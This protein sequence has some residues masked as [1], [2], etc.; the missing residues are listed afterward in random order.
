[1][2]LALGTRLGAYEIVGLLGSGGMGEVYRARDTKL[3]R[4]VAIK[5][6]STAAT[7]DADRLRRFRDEARAASS[8]NHP[9]IL[10][11][12]DFGDVDGRPFIVTELVE[13]ETIGQRLRAGPIEPSETIAIVTQVAR[14]LSA[15]HALGIVH[16]DIKP[17]NV[18]VRP[19]GYVKVLD[20]G[21]AK[22]SDS[23]RGVDAPTELRTT[24]G[25]IVGTPRYM[26][27]EQVRGLPVD[28]R[29]DIW[30]IGVMLYEMIL[31]RP[32]FAGPTPADLAS[33]ILMSEPPLDGL[34]SAAGG[35]VGRVVGRA[36]SKNPLERYADA[37]E[38]IADLAAAAPAVDAMPAIARR[39][40]IAPASG[41]SNLSLQLTSFVGRE[42]D[43]AGV[44]RVLAGARFVMLTGAGGVGKTRL[45]LRVGAECAPHFADGVWFVDLAP[46]SDGAQVTG[47]IAGVLGVRDRPDRPIAESLCDR[48]RA[49]TL[50][51]VLDNCEHLVDACAAL[52][53]QL[54]SACAGIKMLATSREALG[55][56]GE[57]TWR[58]R[59]LGVPEAGVVDPAALMLVESAQLFVQRA[60]AVRPEFDV[61]ADNA[62]AVGHICRRL[63]GLPLAIELA[64]A[65]LRSMSAGEIATRLDDRFR[66][67]TG[68]S[69]AALPRQRTLEATVSWSYELLSDLERLLF[70]RLSVFAG[71]WT[72]EAAEQVCRL[73]GEPDVDIAD[74]IA[75][76]VDRSLVAADETASGRTRYRLLE[77]LRQFGRDR[78]V[79]RG[80]A[81]DVRARHLSWAVAHAERIPPQNTT[82]HEPDVAAEIDNLRT[83]LEWACETDAHEA[84]LRLISSASWILSLA[85]RRR[86]LR[87]LLPFAADAPPAVQSRVLFVAGSLA[88]MVGD[89]RW[90]VETLDA[91]AEISAKTG[92]V[93]HQS[94]SLAYAATCYWALG[95]RETARDRIARAVTVARDGHSGIALTRS[96]CFQA[97]LEMN[98]DLAL[99]ESLAIAG[100]AEAAAF[101]GV[102]DIAHCREA[103]GIIQ[104]L[105]GDPARG[106]DVLAGAMHLFEQIQENC[107]AHILESAAACFAMVGRFELGAELLGAAGRIRDE[108]G[109]RPRP[110]EYLVQEVW[111]PRIEEALAPAEFTAARRRGAQRAFREALRFAQSE[112]SASARD[113]A[114]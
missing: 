39:A 31:G 97:W 113:L 22:L 79:A 57:V 34:A 16:R 9:H 20:F 4:A 54:L 98:R 52:T 94:M 78:L 63:D 43:I 46:L 90:G 14:A 74:L 71:G 73:D 11:I 42:N 23:T 13:G 2:A 87:Q 110:W 12:H 27:P 70:D 95:D 92:D 15:A 25:T 65:R 61:T 35:G 85:E 58:V 59:S 66:L 91:T 21:L 75:H 8:L 19:D 84:G 48:L 37:M 69:R 60:R 49:R 77:T 26:S 89:W 17:E 45:A 81:S 36:L 93:K 76:L 32:P 28:R 82:V 112:L 41:R 107:S 10:V 56:P 83:A 109:D 33:A 7:V 101:N 51:I 6:L 47:A 88:F 1:V 106:A 86:A 64:A 50:L 18:M 55:V 100:E 3:D 99:A 72:V 68:G 103:L 62:I 53:Q 80:M 29:S 30:S 67:L 5:V 104:C 114:D 40:A 24:P 96:L 44:R 111:L 38:L 102:F 105:K 108:T